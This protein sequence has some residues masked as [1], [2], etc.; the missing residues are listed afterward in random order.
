MKKTLSRKLVDIITKD[1]SF[2]DYVQGKKLQPDEKEAKELLKK[3]ITSGVFDK[4][5]YK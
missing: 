4:R 3:H 1:C 5:L 2:K